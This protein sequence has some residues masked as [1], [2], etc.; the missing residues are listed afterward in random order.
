MLAHGSFIVG[1]DKRKCTV[2]ID[3]DMVSNIHAIIDI[4]EHRITIKDLNTTNGTLVNG[5]R[6]V[7][8]TEIEIKVNDTLQF[9]NSEFLVT[10]SNASIEKEPGMEFPEKQPV[11]ENHQIGI[12]TIIENTYRINML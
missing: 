1:K 6:I 9:G 2:F 4:T 10:C 7:S 12:G 11:P 8:N 5:K 3:D